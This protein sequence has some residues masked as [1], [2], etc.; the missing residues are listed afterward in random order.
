MAGILAHHSR[1]I[2]AVV[3]A[4]GKS[5]RVCGRA[6]APLRG[7]DHDPFISRIVRTFRAAGVE[8]IVVVAGHEAERVVSAV[9][10]DRLEARVI[11]NGEFESGQFSSVLAGLRAVDRPGVEAFLL[12]LVDV[13]MVSA[14]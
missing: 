5:T 13:P 6:K 3:L 9:N 10:A 11:V 4:A 12:T 8:E 7:G 14:A 2:P 1:M